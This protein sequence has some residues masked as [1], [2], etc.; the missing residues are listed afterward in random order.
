[1]MVPSLSLGRKSSKEK[2]AECSIVQSKH[3]KMML[4]SEARQ[5]NRSHLEAR[6]RKF[7]NNIIG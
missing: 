2:D 4:T 7:S 5:H 1:M 6:R 3:K